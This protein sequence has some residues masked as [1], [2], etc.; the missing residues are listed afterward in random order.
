[1][2]Q[3]NKVKRKTRNNIAFSVDS[4]LKVKL[5]KFAKQQTEKLNF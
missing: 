5:I 1:M 2:N 4:Y 3:F